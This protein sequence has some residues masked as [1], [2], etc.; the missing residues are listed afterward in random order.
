LLNANPT[1]REEHLNRAKEINN[2]YKQILS[3]FKC[4]LF[5]ALFYEIPKEKIIQELVDQGKEYILSF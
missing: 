3:T 2:V 1:L 5:D 4:A